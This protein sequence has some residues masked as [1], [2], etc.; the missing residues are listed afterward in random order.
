MRPRRCQ[1]DANGA[2]ASKRLP[3][4]GLQCMA[5]PSIFTSYL[6]LSLVRRTHTFQISLFL[7][8]MVTTFDLHSYQCDTQAAIAQ[9]LERLS[10][11]QEVMSSILIGGLMFSPCTLGLFALLNII[12]CPIMLLVSQFDQPQMP[13]SELNHTSSL[14]SW[15]ISLKQLASKPSYKILNYP[16]NA[17]LPLPPHSLHS[18]IPMAEWP[19]PWIKESC[20]LTYV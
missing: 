15:I 14:P 3:T 8:W 7:S 10:S 20:P 12:H 13:S 9:R 11:K 2:S 18:H 19:V 5:I 4:H 1:I 6:I 16:W 17:L